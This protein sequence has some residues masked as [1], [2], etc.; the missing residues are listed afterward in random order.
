MREGGRAEEGSR[1]GLVGG[2]GDR[3]REMFPIIIITYYI[4]S[5]S[6]INNASATAK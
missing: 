5:H 1:V 3:E 4:C 2:R 6:F